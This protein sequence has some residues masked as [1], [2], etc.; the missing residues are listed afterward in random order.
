MSTWSLSRRSRWFVGNLRT[1]QTAGAQ[2]IP[3]VFCTTI[4]S[5]RNFR[6]SLKSAMNIWPYFTGPELSITPCHFMPRPPVQTNTFTCC[7][8]PPLQRHRACRGSKLR[9]P[10]FSIQSRRICW[11]QVFHGWHHWPQV[12]RSLREGTLVCVP[13]WR[14]VQHCGQSV[15]SHV[16]GGH[17]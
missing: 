8:A 12:K 3:Y 2:T 10:L 9:L 11:R 5:T 14:S 7:G 13:P 6:I 4:H 15:C 17:E 1:G 16:G